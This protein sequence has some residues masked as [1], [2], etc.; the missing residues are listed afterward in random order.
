[1]ALQC[2]HEMRQCGVEPNGATFVCVLV[3]CSHEGLVH[4]G[5]E[6]FK[7]MVNNYGIVPTLQHYVCMADLLGRSGSTDEAERLLLNMPMQSNVVGWMCLLSACK[8]HGAMECGKRCFDHVIELEP[9]NA[10]AY[11]LMAG[12]YA[13]AGKVEYVDSVESL[14]K[15]AGACKKPAS[16]WIEVN[17]E[18]KEFVVGQVRC[19]VSS[20]LKSVNARAMVEERHV[21]HDEDVLCGHAEKL[22]LAYGLLNTP[23]G[24]T[25]LVTKN[26]RMCRDCH[27]GT[28]FMSR[29]E[30]R[31]IIVRDAHRVHCFM[32]GTCSCGDR[33]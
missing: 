27:N 23:D 5:K 30:R 9:Q 32:D 12:I 18:V 33:P 25:L 7:M 4:E 2:F 17:R 10:A 15:S 22:A 13:D 28:K 24:A 14:R 31:E 19:D 6:L 29:I 1:M 21:P 20:K 11:V 26:L 16:A 8:R 3:A